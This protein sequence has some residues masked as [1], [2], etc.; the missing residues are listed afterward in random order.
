MSKPGGVEDLELALL[1]EGLYQWYGDDFR[2]YDRERLCA[3]VLAFMRG[4]GLVTISGLQEVVMHDAA[5]ASQF[6]RFIGQTPG[7]LFEQPTALQALRAALLPLLRSCP[8]PRIWVAE[9]GSP[10]PVMTLAILLE[11]EGLYDRCQL[12]VTHANQRVLDR[13]GALH[14]SEGDW[15]LQRRNY[16]ESGGRRT[17]DD[18]FTPAGDGAGLRDDLRRNITWGQHDLSGDAS[19][20]EFQLISCQ[21][22]LAEFGPVLRRRS[23]R[24][25]AESL[26]SFGILQLADGGAVTP[27]PLPVTMHPLSRE[28][29]IYRHIA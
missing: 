10:Q 28:H 26:C 21:R 15:Q 18:Y 6:I 24:I 23:M 19:F 12:F 8:A 1:L 2:S 9:C 27:S 13:A 25:F 11:E 20:N 29:G 3:K 4:R 5:Q 14:V 7:V 17:L 16:L 22:T